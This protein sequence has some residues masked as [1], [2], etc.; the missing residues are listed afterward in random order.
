MPNP[1]CD[2]ATFVELFEKHG[3]AKTAEIL[4][5]EVRKVYSRRVD[6]EKRIGRQLTSP[7]QGCYRTRFAIQHPQRHVIEITDGIILVG[8]DAHY[9][10][11]YVSTAHKAFVRF[12]K[13]LQ[14]KVIVLNGDAL[15]A[16]TISRHPPI[17]WEERPSVASE[18]IATQ[19]R[20]G[21]IQKAAPNA[22]RV[23]PL[24]NHDS[25]YET[26]LATVA[27][28]FAK[29][30]GVHLKDHFPHWRPCWACWINPDNDTV[31]IKHRFKAGIHAPWNNT[32]W[33]GT[34]MITGHLHSL[35]V[36]PFS[37]YKTTR[38][39]VDCGTLAD[40]YGPQFVD[41]TEDNPKNWRAGFIVL[42][43]RAGKL[44]WPE[45]VYVIDENTV[46]FRGEL[47]TV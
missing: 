25:R 2:E 40:V 8:S 30:H 41:Y 1:R 22:E 47:I 15:D 38:F 29:V 31:V 46:G 6:I 12:A 9:W 13:K 27:P 37:D 36:Y 43:F 24:G 33:S 3:A 14:P 34:H 39:G 26:R 23:W 19:E 4:D 45:P 44:M 17:G 16:A 7:T 28:E 10:P 5:I 18:I 11:G 20:L 35:K 21:E 32:M 42:T